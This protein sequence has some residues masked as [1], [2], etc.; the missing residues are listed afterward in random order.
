MAIQTGATD[1]VSRTLSQLTFSF[2][3]VDS[4]TKEVKLVVIGVPS[5]EPVAD[6]TKG[7]FLKSNNA[8]QYTRTYDGDISGTVL[9]DQEDPS[10]SLSLSMAMDYNF[11]KENDLG[12]ERDVLNAFLLGQSIRYGSGKL[13]ML[14]V[15]GNFK[16]GNKAT[17]CQLGHEWGDLFRK[18]WGYLVVDGA[19][20]AET[21]E[22][23]KKKNTL[24][25]SQNLITKAYVME[26]YTLSGS[27]KD[28]NIMNP[29]VATMSLS[30]SEGDTN[31]LSLDLDISAD[32]YSRDGFVFEGI[33]V[34]RANADGTIVEELGVQYIVKSA[35]APTD[36]GNNGDKI[37]MVDPTTGE[38]TIMVS[39]GSAWSEFGAGTTFL[40]YARISAPA[41]T[42]DTLANAVEGVAFISVHTPDATDLSGSIASEYVL[43][44]TG[45][46]KN[47]ICEV[48]M[49]EREEEEFIKYVPNEVC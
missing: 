23:L 8:K 46:T 3:A 9:L 20:N 37:A 29:C 11:I 24:L 12:F 10:A 14:G 15:T 48:L 31:S 7:T 17:A 34:D 4:E 42:E 40:K 27:G 13:A 41:V 39:D 36:F 28:E 30:A 19:F 43:D 26:T 16:T 49:Y 22:P 32:M 44:A 47:Y 1:I 25:Y 5:K 2:L 6:Q 21:Y 35:T 33:V 45:A 18:E 38:I